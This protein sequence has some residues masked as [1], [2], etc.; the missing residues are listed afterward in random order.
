MKRFSLWMSLPALL[1]ITIAVPFRNPAFAQTMAQTP[2]SSTVEVRGT[3]GGPQASSC[4]Q[5][6]SS[7]NQRLQVTEPFA[8]IDISVQSSGDYTLFIQG[9][10]GFSECVLAHDFSDGT[11]ES[12]GVLNQGTY[13]IYV[14]NR[15]G[16]SQPF[17]LRIQQ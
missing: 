15:S 3:S 12:P 7:P 13:E 4:G 14:G 1:G 6:A 9:P 10:N 5:I 2:L 8:S 17:T 16:A 11:I